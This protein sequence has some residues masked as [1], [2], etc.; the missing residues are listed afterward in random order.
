MALVNGWTAACAL[1]R[2]LAPATINARVGGY[3][4]RALVSVI[5]ITAAFW[6]VERTMGML[7]L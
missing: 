5:G 6:F 1:W 2:Q 4:W 3:A 7:G